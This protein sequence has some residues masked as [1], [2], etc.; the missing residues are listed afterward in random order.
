M[1]YQNYY[2]TQKITFKNFLSLLLDILIMLDSIDELRKDMAG[3]IIIKTIQNIIENDIDELKYSYQQCVNKLEDEIETE[4]F[5]SILLIK[6][7]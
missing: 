1:L 2:K 3:N 4:K 5:L 6:I 7:S